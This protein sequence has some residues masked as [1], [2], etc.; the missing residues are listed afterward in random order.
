MKILFVL[1]FLA[2]C[3]P[4]TLEELRCQGEAE[5][6]KITADLRKIESKEDVQK[7]SKR[8]N[9]RFNQIAELLIATRKF[10]TDAAEPSPAGEELFAELARIYEI[11]GAR[12][13]IEAAQS[14]AVHAMDRS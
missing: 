13:A 5:M 7:A 2:G 9:R 12:E 8:L 4:T 10:S 1:L 3:A 6:K 14:E 11:P